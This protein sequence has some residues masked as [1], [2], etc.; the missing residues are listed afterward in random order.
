MHALD[1]RFPT[2]HPT[3]SPTCL[4]LVLNPPLLSLVCSNKPVVVIEKARVLL[5]LKTVEMAAAAAG[6]S[7]LLVLMLLLA[8]L[9]AAGEELTH[10]DPLIRMGIVAEK[11]THFHVYFHEVPVG[12]P[13]AT[14]VLVASQH[15]A[16][17]NPCARTRRN[18]TTFGDLRVF[19][20][21][22]REG[23]DPASPLIGRARG[24]GARA[25]VDGSGALT[26]IEFVFS[27][28]G[29]YS[30]STLAT[31]GHFIRSETVERSIVGGTGELR[32]A[33]GY[34]TTDIISSTNF[35]LVADIHMYFTTAL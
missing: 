27:D 4:V 34:M 7:C 24:L 3:C 29:K 10:P 11:L 1:A 15:N 16:P 25:S 2:Y 31:V 13:N 18:E 19:D 14:S 20:N 28:Y 22:L 30:G 21:A 35:Y 12:A 26:T 32:F 33:R 8:V 17:I 23:P 6:C 5:K 9:L